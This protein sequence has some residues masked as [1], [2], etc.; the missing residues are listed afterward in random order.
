MSVGVAWYNFPFP[1]DLIIYK[2]TLSKTVFE[3][4]M[5]IV[6]YCTG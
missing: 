3:L 6:S 4:L 2:Q 5:L 1:V